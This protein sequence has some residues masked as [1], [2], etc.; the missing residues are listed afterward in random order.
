ML[1]CEHMHYA[2]MLGGG[3]AWL[4]SHSATRVPVPSSRFQ[5][6]KAVRRYC[7]LSLPLFVGDCRREP[8]NHMHKAGLEDALILFE[9]CC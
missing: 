5:V 2:Y 6:A 1:K 4:A 7:C 8:L 3:D 9:F